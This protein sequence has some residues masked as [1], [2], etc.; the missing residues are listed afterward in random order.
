MKISVKTHES[1]L[2][3]LCKEMLGYCKRSQH[4]VSTTKEFAG[5][6]SKAGMGGDTATKNKRTA[7]ELA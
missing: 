4:G 7:H 3:N 5:C 1:N 2:K 6:K